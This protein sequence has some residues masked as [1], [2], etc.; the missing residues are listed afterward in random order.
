[1]D[2]PI[3]RLRSHSLIKRMSKVSSVLVIF[4]F[5][6]TEKCYCL[7][8]RN[9]VLPTYTKTEG[10]GNSFLEKSIISYQTARPNT[11]LYRDVSSVHPKIRSNT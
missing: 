1:M 3:A 9:A 4:H 8:G 5:A 2:T 7:V 6:M 10:G 11:P